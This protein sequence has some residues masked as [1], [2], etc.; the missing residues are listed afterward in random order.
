MSQRD[1]VAGASD[2]LI[3]RVDKVFSE[4]VTCWCPVGHLLA[5]QCVA[6]SPDESVRWG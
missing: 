1:H 3:G 4:Q 5:V 6:L 2:P